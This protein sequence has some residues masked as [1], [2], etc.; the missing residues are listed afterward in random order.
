M[1]RPTAY[2]TG[3][4][5]SGGSVIRPSQG[6]TINA[7]DLYTIIW[8]APPVQGPVDIELWGAGN[9]VPWTNVSCDGWIFNERCV[10]IERNSPSGSTSYG[11]FNISLFS[12][13][14]FFILGDHT[15]GTYW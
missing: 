8:S 1:T 4:I 10:K 6:E 14:I 9:T 2:P 15:R 5:A 11:L 7:G 3:P 13:L 12:P